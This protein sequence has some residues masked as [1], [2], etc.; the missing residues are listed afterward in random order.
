VQNI[1]DVIDG[2]SILLFEK[3]NRK[4]TTSIADFYNC[5]N[6]ITLFYKGYVIVINV[7][8]MFLHHNLV[9][10]LMVVQSN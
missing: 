3:P 6:F 2:I 1:V 7:F 10:L 9:E 4:I 8:G 5:K